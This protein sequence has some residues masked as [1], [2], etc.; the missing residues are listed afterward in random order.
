MDDMMSTG[1]YMV[2]LPGA[3]GPGDDMT[4]EGSYMVKIDDNS[5]QGTYLGKA[6]DL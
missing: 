4:S 6:S 2:R 3:R 5:S 1:S